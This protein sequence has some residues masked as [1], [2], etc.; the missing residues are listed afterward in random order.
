M[1]NDLT[2]SQMRER[3]ALAFKSDRKAEI[4]IYLKEALGAIV[5]QSERFSKQTL[6]RIPDGVDYVELPDDY[7]GLLKLGVLD[8]NC[9]S[10]CILKENKDMIKAGPTPP[11]HEKV[12]GKDSCSNSI[13]SDLT[14]LPDIVEEVIIGGVSY[15]KVIK[16]KVSADGTVFK[17]TTEPVFRNGAVEIMENKEVVCQLSV[18]DG[19]IE[20]S[21]ENKCKVESHLSASLHLG[22]CETYC[23][24]EPESGCG[25]FM[26][27]KAEERIYFRKLMSDVVWLKY[28]SYGDGN[29]ILIPEAARDWIIATVWLK[30]FQ[31]DS[32]KPQ[33]EKNDHRRNQREARKVMNRKFNPIRWSQL[34]SSKRKKIKNSR[35]CSRISPGVCTTC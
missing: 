32:D 34:M 22:G 16:S 12:C 10:I 18:E 1:N 25:T 27:K 20:E 8:P 23:C 6:L 35:S 29:D 13:C 3:I 24:P 17:T 14:D 4:G 28:Y 9:A 7:C 11:K 21:E 26:V 30:M 15:E 31:Y 2:F 5:H 33:Y 19:C